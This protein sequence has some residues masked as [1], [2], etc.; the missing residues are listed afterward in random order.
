MA[1]VS[2]G[3]QGTGQGAHLTGKQNAP[4]GM[5]PA[6]TQLSRGPSSVYQR[7]AAARIDSG[8]QQQKPSCPNNDISDEELTEDEETCSDA[9]LD[10]DD[11][12]YGD[13]S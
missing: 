6:P 13:V 12:D 11:D 7:L 5:K 10:Q 9:G 3:A 1:A 2:S 8:S 4:S